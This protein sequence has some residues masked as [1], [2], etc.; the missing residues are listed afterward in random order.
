MKYIEYIESC[1]D[2]TVDSAVSSELED[3]KYSA[4]ILV[5]IRDIGFPKLIDLDVRKSFLTSIEGL[6]R[7]RMPL[8]KR[9]SL[10]TQIIYIDDNFICNISSSRK[11]PNPPSKTFYISTSNSYHSKHPRQHKQCSKQPNTAPSQLTSV[12]TYRLP[13]RSSEHP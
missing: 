3:A 2:P 7:M 13:A 4:E 5:M 11:L 6:E 9:L 10:G 12:V 8:L 1:Q